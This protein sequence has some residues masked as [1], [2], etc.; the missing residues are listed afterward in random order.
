MSLG[1]SS[2]RGLKVEVAG[3]Y[4]DGWSPSRG[5]A[6]WESSVEDKNHFI[7][8]INNAGPKKTWQE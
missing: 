4:R 6:K 2:L 5:D 1:T 8:S 3:G 7:A